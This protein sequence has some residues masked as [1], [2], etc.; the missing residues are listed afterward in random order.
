MA[1]AEPTTDNTPGP[2]I[3][4]ADEVEK[5]EADTTDD[6]TKETEDKPGKEA[7]KYR[8]QLREAEAERD[9]LR[10]NVEA[11][12]RQIVED[13]AHRE[14]RV[15]KPAALWKADGFTIAELVGEDGRIDPAKVTAAVTA[16]VDAL[17]LRQVDRL[18]PSPNAGREVRAPDPN[19]G[20]SKLLSGN[21]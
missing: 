9:T 18:P 3:D 15:I 21:D 5:T 6:I 4:V 7:A 2:V 10:H 1:T 12:Q 11:L 17:G 14:H 19:D 8:K 13:L 20:W 16:A